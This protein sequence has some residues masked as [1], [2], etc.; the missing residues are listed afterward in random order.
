MLEKRERKVRL[1]SYAKLLVAKVGTVLSL[2]RETKI[3]RLLLLK[4]HSVFL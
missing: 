3:S 4:Y 2:N 1:R